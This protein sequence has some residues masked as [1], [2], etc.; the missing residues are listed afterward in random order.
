MRYR[1]FEEKYD[2]EIRETCEKYNHAVETCLREHFE[3]RFVCE[4]YMK[5]FEKCTNEFDKMFKQ[6]YLYSK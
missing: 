5:A 6:K 4:P 2:V 3:D 1:S